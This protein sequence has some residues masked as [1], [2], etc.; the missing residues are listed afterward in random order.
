VG[1]LRS[2]VK[3]QP[4]SGVAGVAPCE[5]AESVNVDDSDSGM[6]VPAHCTFPQQ[7]PYS[8]LER[9]LQGA[10]GVPCHHMA[11]SHLG[12][13]SDVF[14]PLRCLFWHSVRIDEQRKSRSCGAIHRFALGM[15][16]VIVTSS[17]D[18]PLTPRRVDPFESSPTLE[19]NANRGVMMSHFRSLVP[20]SHHYQP[21]DV[22]E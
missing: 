9:R 10:V 20:L 8:R 7:S 11:W 12:I 17:I 5:C 15:R 13:R 19:D 4:H 18:F 21:L 2:V 14:I 22:I 1:A 6:T 3:H 16:S